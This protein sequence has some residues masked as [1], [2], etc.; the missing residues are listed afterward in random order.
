MIITI[1]F[2]G[3]NRPIDVHVVRYTH[4]QVF[5]EE[6]IFNTAAVEVLFVSSLEVVFTCSDWF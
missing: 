3:E 2:R 6:V 5:F 4:V 1:F